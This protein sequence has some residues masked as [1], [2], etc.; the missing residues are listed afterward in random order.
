MDGGERR[1]SEEERWAQVW[2]TTQSGTGLNSWCY[3]SDD[4][5]S[6]SVSGEGMTDANFAVT[7]G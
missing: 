5:R 6:A 2:W 1:R 3:I 4:P 7:L